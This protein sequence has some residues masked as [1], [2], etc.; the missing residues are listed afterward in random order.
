MEYRYNKPIIE[1]NRPLIDE[2]FDIYHIEGSKKDG[3]SAYAVLDLKELSVKIFS[4][5]F[6]PDHN[7]NLSYFIMMKR[8]PNKSS[9]KVLSDLLEETGD[10]AFKVSQCKTAALD[11]L[12][13]KR[14]LLNGVN[15]SLSEK[16]AY[17]NTSGHLMRLL[18]EYIQYDDKGIS[19]FTGLEIHM[20][21]DMLIQIKAKTFT[22]VDKFSE[23]RQ[24]EVQN[25]AQYVLVEQPLTIRRKMKADV[26]RTFVARTLSH[27]RRRTL[28]PFLKFRDQESF[29]RTKI[30]VI[31]DTTERFNLLYEGIA[32]IK[33]WEKIDNIQRPAI[34]KIR[35]HKK[36]LMKAQKA[37]M[38]KIAVRDLAKDEEFFEA[39][40][41][42]LGSLPPYEGKNIIYLK[43]SEVSDLPT[44][45]II[46]HD[47]EWYESREED[48]H[49]P[50]R[51][52][53]QHIV[54]DNK[55]YRT[56]KG[57]IK[58]SVLLEALRTCLLNLAVKTDL[59]KGKISLYDYSSL[60]TKGTWRFYCALY[61]EER[62]EK[63]LSGITEMAI[64]KN[65]TFTFSD[66]REIWK[67]PDK[68]EPLTKWERARD[69]E[70]LLESP[71]GSLFTIEKT[72]M[73]PLPDED[74][75]LSRINE[76]EEEELMPR[77]D[78][79]TN[80][81]ILNKDGKPKMTRHTL[82]FTGKNE[83]EGF[84]G[85]TLDLSVAKEGRTLLYCVGMHHDSLQQDMARGAIIRRVVPLVSTDD[86]NEVVSIMPLFDNIFVRNGQLSVLPFPVKYIHEH[87]N[88]IY[89]A[90]DWL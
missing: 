86:V 26:C 75:I 84:F 35:D 25:A 62:F 22:A 7:E 19:S 72:H 52:D 53:I 21:K 31:T 70:C 5:V 40:K 43:D 59:R 78:P 66:Y 63:T 49:R 6:E 29:D 69:I 36:N 8:D 55:E 51:I 20:D 4:L 46:P 33:G 28:I 71:S 30:G 2:K 80:E 9:R 90:P 64:K 45:V 73:F 34:T 60:E 32:E 41:E 13:L 42:A 14:L 38:P 58:P 23:N 12:T 81:I 88:F 82:G 37:L 3:V 47:W 67:V 44:L 50:D 79:D 74:A 87:Q 15:Q 1:I 48:P 61:R 89:P 18:P 68:L 83:I 85:A 56:A 16:S 77:I 65:G 76:R 54:A 39:V 27:G 57:K 17:S 11:S 10:A 24:K